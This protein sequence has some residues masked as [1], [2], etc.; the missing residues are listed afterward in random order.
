MKPPLVIIVASWIAASGCAANATVGGGADGGAEDDRVT[1]VTDA[2]VSPDDT[3][4][5]ETGAPRYSDVHALFDSRCSGYCHLRQFSETVNGSLAL[6]SM[7]SR[8]VPGLML[9]EPGDPTAS[10]L[11][12]K[13][14]GTMNQLPDCQ[15]PDAGCGVPMP[16]VYQDGHWIVSLSATDQELIRAWIAAGAPTSDPP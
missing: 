16:Q 1:V 13:V 10:Y 12:L 3:A 9:V 6:L 14:T 8:E 11:Y 4:A 5:A 2:A 7:Q 15:V